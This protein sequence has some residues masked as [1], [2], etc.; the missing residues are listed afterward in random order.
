ML[1]F[2]FQI[3]KKTGVSVWNPKIL[4]EKVLKVV[5][6]SAPNVKFIGL[7]LCLRLM[8]FS[9]FSKQVSILLISSKILKYQLFETEHFKEHENLVLCII[10]IIKTLPLWINFREISEEQLNQ[11]L[12]T[13]I[14]LIQFLSISSNSI[15]LCFQIIEFTINEIKCKL[16]IYILLSLYN[17]L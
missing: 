7:D 6:I 17:K 9:L 13:C 15:E 2:F 11:F 1:H 3:I 10:E 4:S 5:I 14:E 16:I 12:Q 8:E